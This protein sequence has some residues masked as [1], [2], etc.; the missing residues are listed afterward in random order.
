MAKRSTI[1][2]EITRG[3]LLISGLVSLGVVALMMLGRK[4]NP[5]EII[6]TLMLSHT[7]P[8]H[9]GADGT[10]TLVGSTTTG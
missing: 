7:G 3:L 9:Q 5:V 4:V 10:R 1:N 8:T 2:Y 6:A